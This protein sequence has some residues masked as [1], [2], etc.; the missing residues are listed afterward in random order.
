MFLALFPWQHCHPC[1]WTNDKVMVSNY[2]QKSN[3]QSIESIICS[4]YA[5]SAIVIIQRTQLNWTNPF[6]RFKSFISYTVLMIFVIRILHC[7]VIRNFQSTVMKTL[8]WKLKKKQKQVLYVYNMYLRICWL[9]LVV[10]GIY[11]QLMLIFCR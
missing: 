8:F 3:V 11:F 6:G 7:A 9:P 2:K 10:L 1:L 5:I 4:N